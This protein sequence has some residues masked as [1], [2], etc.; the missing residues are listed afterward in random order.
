MRKKHLWLFLAVLMTST[1]WWPAHAVDGPE[2]Q[3]PGGDVSARSSAYSGSSANAQS[4]S[5]SLAGAASHSQS[6]AQGGQANA[7]AKG[8]EAQGGVATSDISG[9]VSLNNSTDIPRQ[10]PSVG[11]VVPQSDLMGC[12]KGFGL[13]GSEERG[14]V[15]MGWSWLQKDCYAMRQFELFAALGLNDAAGKAFCSRKSHWTPFESKDNCEAMIV[16]SLIDLQTD[17][18]E[19]AEVKKQIPKVSP[20][21]KWLKLSPTKP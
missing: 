15:V 12:T 3:P 6:S 13:G 5:A 1:L 4:S 20:I 7:V 11:L 19:V 16:Q 18:A 14:S 8:G 2:P 21:Q 10:A 9:G 17:R